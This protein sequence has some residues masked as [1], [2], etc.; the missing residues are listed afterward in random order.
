MLTSWWEVENGG[1]FGSKKGMGLPRADVHLLPAVS[2]KDTQELKFGVEQAVH[3]M[4][5]PFFHKEIGVHEV[6]KVLAEKG[7]KSRLSAKSRAVKMCAGLMRFWK[8]VIGSW[9]LM[10]T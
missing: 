8:A 1:S 5:S 9:W 2:E 10:V 3:M 6:R 4:F 7:N